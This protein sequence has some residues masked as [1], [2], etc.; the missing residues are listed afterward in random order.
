MHGGGGTTTFNLQPKDLAR[1]R[2]FCKLNTQAMLL[3]LFVGCKKKD[4]PHTGKDK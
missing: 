3:L 4:T 2:S 1:S